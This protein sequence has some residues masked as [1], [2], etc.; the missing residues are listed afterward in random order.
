MTG[1]AYPLPFAPAAPWRSTLVVLT[2][3]LAGACT[4]RRGPVSDTHTRPA[5]DTAEPDERQVYWGDLHAHSGLSFDGCED[6]D[7]LCVAAGAT[8]AEDFFVHAADH[9]LAF[10]ALTDHAEFVRYQRPADG[11]DLDIWD[12]ARARVAAA[13]GGP[14]I[15]ILGYEWTTTG[16]D[17]HRTV[18]LEDPSA[19]AA[20]RVGGDTPFNVKTER[21]GIETYVPNTDAPALD[22]ASLATALAA[23][24]ATPGCAPTRWIAFQHHTA[25]T[26]PAGVDFHDASC[27]LASDRVIEMASEHGSSECAD[28]EAPGCAWHLQAEVYTPDGSVQTALALGHG[29]GFVGGTDRHDSHPGRVDAGPSPSGHLY[30]SDGDGVDDTPYDQFTTG[31]LTGVVAPPPLTRAAVFDALDARHTY[32]ASWPAASL[33]VWAERT[34]GAGYLPGDAVPEGSYRVHIALADPTVTAWSASLL[35]EAGRERG[36]DD[37]TVWSIGPG[38]LRYVRIDATVAGQTQRVWASPFFGVAP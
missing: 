33:W 28:P 25:E 37:A 23:A 6:P 26:A 3:L 32:A 16:P 17:G 18:L 7:N 21:I 2:A 5:P 20:F 12:T 34:D 27:T 19:C 29:L 22:A 35:D 9:G 11:V 38:E 8:P 15:P 31:T 13:D 14:V 30:D 24:A 10:A 4:G 36:W 1:V